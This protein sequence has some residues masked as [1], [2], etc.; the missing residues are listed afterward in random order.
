MD[1]TIGQHG[2]SEPR[3]DEG[4][5]DGAVR[6]GTEPAETLE[7]RWFVSGA[8]P[9]RLWRLD[10]RPQT[11]VDAYHDQSLRLSLSLKRRGELGPW[12]R[13]HRVERAHVVLFGD[14]AV[15]EMWTKE[16]PFWTD[17]PAGS[18][19]SVS[20]RIWR[21]SGVEV[22]DLRLEDERWW[23]VAVKLRPSSPAFESLERLVGLAASRGLSGSYP[24]WLIERPVAGRPSKARRPNAACRMATAGTT[25]R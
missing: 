1:L 4:D 12:E 2:A 23:S 18:W 25:Q 8:L 17:P 20:E 7:V 13:K 5:R 14:I 24:A 15:A 11:R 9:P 21:P 19:T 10:R 6:R 22:V 16:P 3:F